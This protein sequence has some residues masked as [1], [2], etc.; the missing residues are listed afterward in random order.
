M[1]LERPRSPEYVW[2]LAAP[3]E[4]WKVNV[5]HGSLMSSC[6]VFPHFFLNFGYLLCDDDKGNLL[7][8]IQF[9]VYLSKLMKSNGFMNPS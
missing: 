7:C 1:E 8:E 2:F 9:L 3:G 5:M 4:T 6:D